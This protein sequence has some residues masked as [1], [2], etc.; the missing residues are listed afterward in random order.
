[1]IAKELSLNK[2]IERLMLELDSLVEE[3]ECNAS[4]EDKDTILGTK[5]F[6]NQLQIAGFKRFPEYE[7]QT[8]QQK[9]YIKNILS[10]V[11]RAKY[12][13]LL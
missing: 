9:Q 1:M 11:P 5:N 10:K 7:N 4:E 8:F 12:F 2:L 13:E 6:L 3:F